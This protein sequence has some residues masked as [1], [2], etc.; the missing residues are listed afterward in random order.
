MIYNTGMFLLQRKI[1]TK[2]QLEQ[3]QKVCCYS[4]PFILR[5]N[6]F[7]SDILATYSSLLTGKYLNEEASFKQYRVKY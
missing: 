3:I 6:A 1:S 5:G 2:E 7:H 4:E